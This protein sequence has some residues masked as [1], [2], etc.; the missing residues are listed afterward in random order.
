MRVTVLTPDVSGNCLGRA[1]VLARLLQDRHDVEVIGPRLAGGI[2]EPLAGDPSVA[3]HA[4]EPRGTWLAT[5]RALERASQGEALV[6]SKPLLPSLLPALRRRRGGAAVLVDVDD[7]ELGF[8]RD[9]ARNQG[10]LRRLGHLAYS[11]AHPLRRDSSWSVRWGERNV[12]SGDG[13]TTSN[14]FLQQRYGGTLVW[15]A[16]DEGSLRPGLHDGLAQRRALGVRDGD[17]LVMFLGTPAR[18]KGLETLAS[19]VWKA[20]VDEPRI[21]LA[22]VGLQPGRMLGGGAWDALREARR[23]HAH[24]PVPFTEMP[25][26]LAAADVV[27]IPQADTPAARAQMPAKVFDALAMGKPVVV[28]AVGDLPHVVGDAGVAVPADDVEGWKAALVRLAQDAPLRRRLGAAAR[29]RFLERFSLAAVRPAMHAALE[30]AVQAR[31][32]AG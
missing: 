8:T 32:E 1:H 13:V 6:V 3:I 2:W 16:R 15:H 11:A 27:A 26:W 25:A 9:R 17:L 21:H 18:H 30:K 7:W 10:P 28:S 24:G 5:L 19:A 20:V 14:R 29:T 12:R 31:S 22:V 23:L 4:V